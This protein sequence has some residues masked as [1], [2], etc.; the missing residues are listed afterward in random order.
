MLASRPTRG[1]NEKLQWQP[2]LNKLHLDGM[3][4]NNGRLFEMTFNM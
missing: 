2:V 1:G 4:N 3:R